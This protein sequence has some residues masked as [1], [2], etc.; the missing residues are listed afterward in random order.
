M[1]PNYSVAILILLIYINLSI[2]SAF[3]VYPSLLSKSNIFSIL[4]SKELTKAL[5]YSINLNQK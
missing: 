1:H 5:L 4:K 2:S 3:I